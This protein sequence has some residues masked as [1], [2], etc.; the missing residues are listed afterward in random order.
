MQITSVLSLIIAG[1]IPSIVGFI[2]YQPRFFGAHWMQL[3][4][5]QPQHVEGSYGGSALAF[6]GLLSGMVTAF[7]IRQEILSDST[8]V[9]SFE[10]VSLLWLGLIA[11]IGLGIVLW[12]RK[13]VSLY[14][15]SSIYWL[16]SLLLM[17]TV[18]FYLH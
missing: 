6:L 17:T 9:S 8:I 11:M 4:G 5:I 14:L 12:E 10:H 7:V 2:W 1:I 3:S 13:P 15:T 18:L 16:V